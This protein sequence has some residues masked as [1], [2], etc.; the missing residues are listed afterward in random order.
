RIGLGGIPLAVTGSED[1]TVVVWDLVTGER[2]HSLTGHIGEIRAVGTVIGLG[3]IPLA[4]TGSEDGTVIVWDLATGEH[5]HTLTGHTREIRAVG[6]AIGPGGVP[7]A[8]TAS[9]DGT[10]IVWDL[11]TG[12]RLADYRLK[13]QPQTVATTSQGF[14]VGY[15]DEV[16]YFA[17]S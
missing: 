11:A 13:Y 2:L 7:L 5:L 14:I 6:T 8:V 4:V 3:G 1:G 16:A 15:R 10:V 9:G 12:K 17:F